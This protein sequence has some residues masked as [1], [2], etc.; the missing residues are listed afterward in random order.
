[1][2]FQER[3]CNQIVITNAAPIAPARM[4]PGTTKRSA[5]RRPSGEHTEVVG[6]GRSLAELALS[7]SQLADVD[8]L[9]ISG[10]GANAAKKADVQISF[11]NFRQ[12]Q[13]VAF[14]SNL[15]RSQG[16]GVPGLYLCPANSIVEI[17]VAGHT[18]EH[19]THHSTLSR[20]TEH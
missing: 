11:N 2:F 10:V 18:K 17:E 3:E 8:I 12:Q 5:G 1:M 7:E 16:A 6:V 14:C 19:A 9:A 13:G 4:H 15:Y 20:S